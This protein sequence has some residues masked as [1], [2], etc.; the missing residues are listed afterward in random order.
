MKK[1]I[2]AI[3][4]ICISFNS[5]T[6]TNNKLKE[7]VK[8]LSSYKTYQTNCNYTFSMPFGDALNFET[9]IVTQQTP[10][11]TLC[12]FYYAFETNEN[13]RNENF[14]DFTMYFKKAVYKSYKSEVKKISFEE[15]PDAF[16]DLK[17]GGGFRPA[18]QR[19]SQLYYIT[20]NQLA[21]K[22]N[23]LIE[24]SN[25][26]IIQMPD[27]T[28]M[29]EACVRFIIESEN[30]SNALGSNNK[31]TVWSNID[32]CFHK[33]HLYPVYYNKDVKSDYMN[34]YQIAYFSDT[35][36]NL[37]LPDNYFSEENLL[38][39]NWQDENTPVM[40]KNPGSLIGEKAPDWSL[41]ILD[42]NEKLSNNDLNGKYILLEFTASWCVHCIEA[43]E[44]MN[45]LEEQFGGSEKVAILSIFSSN[46]DKKEGIQKFAEKHNLKSK[47][48][49]S[50]SEVGEKFQVYGYP[51]FII[52]SPGG[53]VFMNFPGYSA[54]VEKNIINLLSEFTK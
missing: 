26:T 7:I 4:F 11:D 16:V 21:M 6:Q 34:Q 28:V 20:P 33:S 49:Y 19:S 50:A 12:G 36:V 37:S 47:I 17:M 43:A 3:L 18:I 24:D 40:N 52:I 42:K 44:M 5:F 10:T 45:R 29:N 1:S 48:L 8:E 51:N 39:K 46:I 9:S 32:L 15:K 23:E 54:G 27:T 14:G 31:I 38:P 53:K 2:N 22:I 41:P 25:S 35:R 30:E 13:F